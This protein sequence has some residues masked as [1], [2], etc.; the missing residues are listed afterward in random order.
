M[1][2]P[3]VTQLGTS[4][5]LTVSHDD[6]IGMFSEIANII[7]ANGG[8]SAIHCCGKCDWRIPIKAGVDIIN[9]DAYALRKI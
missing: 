7:K 3:S 9:L 8:I 5:Y 4:A 6:V 1:D 2:E